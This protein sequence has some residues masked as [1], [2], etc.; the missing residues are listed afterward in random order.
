M[1]RTRWVLAGTFL[2]LLALVLAPRT[3]GGGPF[4]PASLDEVVAR[5][6]A[7]GKARRAAAAQPPDAS[8]SAPE[9]AP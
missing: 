5:V 4:I 8:V 7:G 9:A 3:T 1:S 6:P 2:A